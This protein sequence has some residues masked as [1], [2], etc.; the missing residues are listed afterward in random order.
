MVSRPGSVPAHEPAAWLGS[1]HGRHT[2]PPDRT[3]ARCRAGLA[4]GV[5]A[6]PALRGPAERRRHRA[7]PRQRAADDRAV[8]PHRPGPPRAG[9]RPPGALVLPPARVAE[10][11]GAGQRHLPAEQPLH[12]PVDGEALGV[13]RDDP[14]RP[15]GAADDPR[16][17]QEPARQPPLGLHRGDVQQAVRPRRDRRRAGLPAL[18]EAVRRRRMAWRQPG[19]RPRGPAPGVRRVRRDADAP[20]GDRRLRPLRPRAVD[21]ARDDG[22]G[23]PSRG[24]DAQPVRRQ[25]RLPQRVGRQAGGRRLADRQRLLPLGVQLRGDAGRRATRST[26]STTP[27]PARTSPSPPC[28]TTS[29][30]RSARW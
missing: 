28:T 16:A 12:V 14:A 19:E 29:R 3:P 9:H 23:L 7:P 21:R 11:G 15:E 5:R 18:H 25:P 17:V 2:G 26:R 1:L 6:D 22:D 10:E 24:A 4:P 27:T 20:P 30:G 13:L 8:R